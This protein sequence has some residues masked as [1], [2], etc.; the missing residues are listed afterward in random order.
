M[1]VSSTSAA[2]VV[3]L[4]LFN[5]HSRP[6]D[7][8]AGPGDLLQKQDFIVCVFMCVYMCKCRHI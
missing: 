4:S 2:G 5:T 6:L 8:Q 7:E 3:I 1:A